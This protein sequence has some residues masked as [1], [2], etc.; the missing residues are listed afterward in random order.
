MNSK[1][2]K[3]SSNA[4][5]HFILFSLMIIEWAIDYNTDNEILIY[6]SKPTVMT[7]MAYYLYTWVPQ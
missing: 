2:P 4:F 7:L 3:A 6:I 5:G 1:G